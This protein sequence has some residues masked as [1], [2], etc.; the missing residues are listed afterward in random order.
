MTRFE[1]IIHADPHPS[2]NGARYTI[3]ADGRVKVTGSQRECVRE[4]AE[5]LL[6]L[7]GEDDKPDVTAMIQQHNINVC[8]MVQR[9]MGLEP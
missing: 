6:R 5:F 4:L 2:R 7:D 9:A 3:N 1:I 8:R